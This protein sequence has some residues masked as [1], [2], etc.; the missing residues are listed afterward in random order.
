MALTCLRSFEKHMDTLFRITHSGTFNISIQALNLIYQVTAAKESVSSRFYRTLY[1]SLLDPRL[2]ASSKQAM[3]LNLL[4]KAIKTDVNTARAAAFVKR[5]MQ[6]LGTHQPPFICGAFFLFGELFSSLP[7]LRR[8]LSEPEEDDE[9]EHFVDAPD[10]DEEPKK[11]E[12][13]A[14]AA[15][16]AAAAAAVN[17]PPAEKKWDTNYDGKKRDPQYAHAEGSCLWEIVPFLHHFH[18][19]VAL[20]ASQLLNNEPISTSSD[21]NLNTLSHFLDRFVYRNAKKPKA[22]GASIMQPAAASDKSGVVLMM[23]GSNGADQEVNSAAF[24]R[25]KEEDVPADQVRRRL[26]DPQR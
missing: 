9:E 25:Q 7:G 21:L 24:W 2:A 4:F 19:S 23:K 1:E 14:A 26:L 8:M 13:K 3:Y 12:K 20:H 16:A 5:T 17:L 22:K 11:V 6:I 10:P 18:P 15:V